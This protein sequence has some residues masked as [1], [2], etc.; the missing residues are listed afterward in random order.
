MRGM[1]QKLY[2]QCTVE[3]LY[4]GHFFRERIDQKPHRKPLLSGHLLIAD[5]FSRS[6]WCPLE[7]G[8]TVFLLLT[9]KIKLWMWT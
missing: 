3:P 6:R 8:S 2:L 4:N 1:I 7:R 5:T 9:L